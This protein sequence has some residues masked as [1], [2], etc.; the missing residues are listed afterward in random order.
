VTVGRGLVSPV[1]DPNNGN[2]YVTDVGS[3]EDPTNTGS[4]I[5]TGQLM[6]NLDRSTILCKAV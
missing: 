2:V 3:N 5:A 1:F 4:I 6:L